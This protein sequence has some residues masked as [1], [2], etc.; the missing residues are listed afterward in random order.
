M[1]AQNLKEVE[2]V[3]WNIVLEIWTIAHP[4]TIIAKVAIQL[5]AA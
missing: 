5:T 4:L 2:A 3:V 1:L